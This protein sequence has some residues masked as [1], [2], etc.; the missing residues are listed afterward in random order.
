MLVW[1][2]MLHSSFSVIPGL[3]RL[4]DALDADVAH[5]HR[6]LHGHDLL[7]GLDHARQLERLL[8]V[9]QRDAGVGTGARRRHGSQRSTARR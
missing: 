7:R 5:V 2:R 9:E 6:Q 1:C 4:A 8:G 3:Q